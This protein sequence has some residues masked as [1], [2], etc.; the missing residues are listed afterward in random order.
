MT[1]LSPPVPIHAVLFD[2]DGT[3]LDTAPDLAKALNELLTLNSKPPLPYKQIRNIVSQGSVA[4]T[5]LGFPEVTEGSAFEKLRLKLLDCYAESIC[6]ETTLFDEMEKL[7]TTIEK[8][9]VPWG[10]VTNKPGWLTQPLL[11]KLSLL[12]RA[13]CVVSGDT[14]SHRKPHPDPLLH[15]CKQLEVS[16]N[17]SMYIGDDPRDI[18]AGN[19]AGMYTCVASYGYIEPGLEVDRWGA[20]F[21]IASPIELF[22]YIQLTKQIDDVGT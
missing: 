19:A 2:L 9:E 4:L 12:D 11:Q 1:H 8:E 5:R 18:Y 15:A 7:L 16:P 20:D 13:A 14:I 22:K 17:Y 3:L 21:S 6:V 10:V